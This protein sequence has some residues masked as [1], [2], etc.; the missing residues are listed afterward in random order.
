MISRCFCCCRSYPGVNITNFTTSWRNGLGFN[1]LIHAHRLVMI[2][3]LCAWS[4]LCLCGHRSPCQIISLSLSLLPHP[5]PHSLVMSFSVCHVTIVC[6]VTAAVLCGYDNNSGHGSS[7]L[8]GYGRLCPVMALS[9]KFWLRRVMT[10]CMVMAVSFCMI[11]AV[12]VWL[13][14][15]LFV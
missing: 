6:T 5:P 1:A 4:L 11:M 9:L 10:V 7:C 3:S 2:M 12:S 15:C 13:W 14:P 8:Y